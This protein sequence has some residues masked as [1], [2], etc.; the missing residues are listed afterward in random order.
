MGH[1]VAG[2]AGVRVVVPC[3]AQAGG[4]FQDDVWDAGGFKLDCHAQA[5]I[6]GTHDNHFGRLTLLQLSR[7]KRLWGLCVKGGDG[8]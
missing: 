8:G 6:T 2:A 4:L 5:G 3:P 7:G 1:D